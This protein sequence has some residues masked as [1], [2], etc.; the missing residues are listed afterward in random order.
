MKVAKGPLRGDDQ[1]L[2]QVL[3]LTKC[4]CRNKT[5]AFLPVLTTAAAASG[6]RLAGLSC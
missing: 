4:Q 1:F 6:G 3:I 2:A 5:P